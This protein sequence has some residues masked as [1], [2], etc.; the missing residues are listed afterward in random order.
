[1]LT[2]DEGH[3]DRRIAQEAATLAGHGWQVDIHP[4]VDAGLTYEDD[5]PPGVR[6]LANPEL[7][8]RAPGPARRLLRRIKGAVARLSPPAGRLIETAQ[9]RTRDIAAEIFDANLSLLLGQEPFDLVFAHDVPVMPLAA[10]LKDAWGAQLIS[11]LHEVFPEQDEYFTSDT[12]RRYWRA[13]EGE[14]LAVSDGIICVNPAV[15]TYVRAT[16][17]PRAPIAVVHNAVPYVPP[18]RLH[19]PLTLRSLYPIPDADRILLF[20]G[21]L[22]PHK[23]LEVLIDGFAIAELEGWV[24]AILGG[25]PLR[26]EL[27]ARIAGL[28]IGGRVFIGQR[29][30]ER[31]LIQVAA[32]AD[33]ALLPYQVVGF[34]YQ[35]A[36]PN[37]LFEYIQARLPIA[38][39][40]LPEI[41]RIVSPL[42]TAGFIDFSSPGSMAR[43]L[44]TFLRDVVPGI[45][46]GSLEA[47]AAAASWE[48]EEPALLELVGHLTPASVGTRRPEEQSS[49]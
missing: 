14:G 11:D 25:G 24:L 21:S 45:A 16:Y 40:R 10:R 38:T 8:T 3:L 49:A 6:L 27:E 12:A 36:T 23:G 29:A 35:I 17:A 18:A 1:M 13:L 37:K 34:N 31:D 48:R 19:G 9:Y 47:A 4:A 22:R 32:S 28:G 42:G 5:V 2:P 26:G 30:H 41:E 43:G 33:V 46:P 39:S 15:A 44:R 7:P 20:A